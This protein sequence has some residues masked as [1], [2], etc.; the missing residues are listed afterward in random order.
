MSTGIVTFLF[1]EMSRMVMAA[2][3]EHCLER[4]TRTI[5]G[6]EKLS[7]TT[8]ATVKFNGN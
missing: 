6:G 3:P 7:Q 2:R 5:K 1:M 4:K 8:T